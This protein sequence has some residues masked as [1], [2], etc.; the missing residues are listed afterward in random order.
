ML[1]FGLTGVDRAVLLLLGVSPVAFVTVAFAS[2][3]NLDTKLAT[4]T[5][6][7]A[8]AARLVLSSGIVLLAA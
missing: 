2:L 3:E 1:A 5:L 7:L 4:S 6:S 8:M